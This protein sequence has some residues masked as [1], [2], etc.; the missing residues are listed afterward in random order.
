[1][2]SIQSQELE[3]EVGDGLHPQLVRVNRNLTERRRLS[4]LNQLLAS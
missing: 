1:M 4:A 3:D 2:R